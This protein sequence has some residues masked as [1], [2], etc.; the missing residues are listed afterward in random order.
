[1][2]PGVIITRLDCDALACEPWKTTEWIA[3]LSEQ[4]VI[5]ENS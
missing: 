4:S 3:G 1:M 2:V 5:A